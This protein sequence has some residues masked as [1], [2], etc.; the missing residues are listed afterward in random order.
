MGRKWGCR[1]REAQPAA[2][3]AKSSSLLVQTP[4]VAGKSCEFIRIPLF[5]LGV[6]KTNTVLFLRP[7][8][9]LTVFLQ[10]LCT[11]LICGFAAIS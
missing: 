11:L 4:L 1:P 5:D 10:Q 3:I 7:T 8:D 6:M 2:P 9:S